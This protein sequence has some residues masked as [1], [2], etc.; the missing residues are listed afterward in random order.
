M[1]NTIRSKI[2]INLI[3]SNLKKRIKLKILKYNRNILYKSNSSKKDF[4]DFIILKDFNQKFNLNIRDIDIDILDLPNMDLNNEI[5]EYLKILR[6][7]DLLAL[8]LEGNNITDIKELEKVKYEKLEDLWLN[9]NKI[10][11]IN[12]LEKVNFKELIVLDLSHNEITD[13]SV[14]IN[15]T[16]PKL[17]W[18]GLNNNK[19]SDINILANTN[20]KE[21][22][23][24]DLGFNDII[25]IDILKMSSL[26]N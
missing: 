10:S 1:L 11:D 5:F 19:I 4:E 13:M 14:L 12:I 22:Y 20:F 9:N 26:K 24:L 18:L 23:E 3:F 8:Y 21:L 16:F 17:K 15:C 6:F 7:N 2:I 25:D